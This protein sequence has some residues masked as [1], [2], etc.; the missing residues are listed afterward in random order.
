MTDILDQE[1]NVLG[2][3]FSGVGQPRIADILQC[4][5]SKQLLDRLL[6]RDSV[7]IFRDSLFFSGGLFA[8]AYAFVFFASQLSS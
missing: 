4:A 7:R 2:D 8:C 1:V 6:F 5:C 3:P